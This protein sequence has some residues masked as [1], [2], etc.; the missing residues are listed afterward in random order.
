[1]W[2]RWR[3]ACNTS[4]PLPAPPADGWVAYTRSVDND[5]TRLPHEVMGA[6]ES[7][8][9]PLPPIVPSDGDDTGGLTRPAP[10][11][12]PQPARQRVT[13][14]ADPSPSSAPQPQPEPQ[15][16]ADSDGRRRVRKVTRV[17]RQVDTWSVFKVALVFHLFLY[18]TLLTAGVLLWKVAQNTGTVDNVQRFFESFGWKSFTLHGGAIYHQAWV[19]GLFVVVG[20]TGLAVLGATLFNLITD[21]VGGV[22]VTVLEE[23][24]QALADSPRSPLARLKVFDRSR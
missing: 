12:A 13:L 7:G 5:P 23:E 17:I 22:R 15:P 9:I 16:V 3:C 18:V 1:M 11:P 21:L 6:D 10:Q 24:V 4:A 2:W 19:L 14:G 20:L 8:R